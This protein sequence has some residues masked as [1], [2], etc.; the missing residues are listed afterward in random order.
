MTGA[1]L[2]ATALCRRLGIVRPVI[3][4]GMGAVAT[5][6]LGVLA[7]LNL[8]AEVLARQVAEVRAA[9][10]KPFGIHDLPT[11]AEIVDRICIQAETILDQLRSV[12]V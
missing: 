5:G 2:P 12:V 8:P 9:T 4:S 6:G 10:D 11:A 7:G 3:S 1:G